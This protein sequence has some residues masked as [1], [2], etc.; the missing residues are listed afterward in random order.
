M[1]AGVAEAILLPFP[2]EVVSVPIYLANPGRAFLY[3]CI[4]VICSVIGSF[5]GYQVSGL[6]GGIFLKKDEEHKA[7][8]KIKGWYER[9]AIVTLLTSAV[10]PI[11]YE[12]YVVTAGVLKIEK[13]RF[14]AGCLLSRLLRHLPQGMLITFGGNKLLE[15]VKDHMV[16][17]VFI[18]AIFAL[19]RYFI[20][21]K[22]ELKK[23]EID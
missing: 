6:L 16:V 2:M 21:K 4:L 20:N 5:V 17:V 14:F 1:F 18:V 9:N 23:S 12:L 15:F 8:T 10:T 11:P 22:I 7:M 13:K 3:A 19:V